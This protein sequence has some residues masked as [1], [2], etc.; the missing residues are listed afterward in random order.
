MGACVDVSQGSPQNIQ[1]NIHS[2]LD[3]CQNLG[4]NNVSSPNDA[5]GYLSGHSIFLVIYTNCSNTTSN[6]TTYVESTD[7]A[8]WRG[9]T[10]TDS[11]ITSK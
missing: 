1:Q 6:N 8:S 7:G 11:L 10:F 4:T 2:Y 5:K 9:L 3:G